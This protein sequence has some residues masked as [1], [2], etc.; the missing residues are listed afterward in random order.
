VAKVF[1]IA[2]GSLQLGGLFAGSR[3]FFEDAL[4]TSWRSSVTATRFNR[5]WRLSRWHRSGRY[6]VGRLG[7]MGA[8]QFT[9]IDWD[10]E[11]E[12]FLVADASGG[13][14]VPVAVRVDL[15]AV[16]FQLRSGLIR[17]TSVTGAM[18]T[19][20]SRQTPYEWHVTPFIVE[21]S[22]ERW[23]EEVARVTEARFRIDRPNPDWADRP[24]VEFIIDDLEAE[25]A[26]L[27]AKAEEG[28]GLNTDGD[29]FRQALDHSLRS[30]G[31]AVVRGVDAHENETEWDSDGG[32]TIP[33][34]AEVV[35]GTEQDEVPVE[36]LL[37]AFDE[38]EDELRELGSG[39]E[40]DGD[41]A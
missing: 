22:F 20:L 12:D 16:A 29:L 34:R 19:L 31:R 27:V 1:N 35:S 9:T 21:R 2:F 10:E 32:G 23:A 38:R 28:A 11:E 13:A 4:Q 39:M 30:Y 17:P 6:Y 18:Q 33:V 37:Q 36:D 40:P 15:G 8:A 26:R 25:V 7:F 41:E 5:T 14:I 24:T 3:K